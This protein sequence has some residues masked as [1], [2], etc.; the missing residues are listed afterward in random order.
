[1][2]Y[3]TRSLLRPEHIEADPNSK[4]KLDGKAFDQLAK[5]AV[6]LS[7]IEV[8]KPPPAPRPRE[9]LPINGKQDQSDSDS[10]DSD[11]ESICSLPSQTSNRGVDEAHGFPTVLSCKICLEEKNWWS[12]GPEEDLLQAVLR[13]THW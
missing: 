2:E 13:Y 8:S 3:F 7:Q 5:S 4:L 6:I 10:P 1:M 11:T 9:R 12:H